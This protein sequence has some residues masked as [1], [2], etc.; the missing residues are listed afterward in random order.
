MS[1]ETDDTKQCLKIPVMVTAGR[2]THGPGKSS[3]VFYE[4]GTMQTQ[5]IQTKRKWA[6]PPWTPERKERHRAGCI[7]GVEKWRQVEK[8]MEYVHWHRKFLDALFQIEEK[9]GIA[10]AELMKFFTSETMAKYPLSPE[11]VDHWNELAIKK[12]STEVIYEQTFGRAT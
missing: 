3:G 10:P 8:E 6:Q 7:R 11:Q 5:Q 9:Y 2:F 12:T 1:Y 4:E